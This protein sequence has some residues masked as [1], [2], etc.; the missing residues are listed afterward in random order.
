MGVTTMVEV[1]IVKTYLNKLKQL[2]HGTTVA[3][4]IA[5]V[6]LANGLIDLNKLIG[7][8]PMEKGVEGREGGGGNH[9]LAGHE[10]DRQAGG[11][12]RGDRGG[13]N[14]RAGAAAEVGVL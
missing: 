7:G 2:D 4:T 11:Y 8:T 13:G 12:R 6:L 1:G 9:V 5:A 10:D 14:R 3:G